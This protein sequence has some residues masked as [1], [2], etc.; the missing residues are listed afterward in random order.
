MAKTKLRYIN[1]TALNHQETYE[2]LVLSVV[3][4]ILSYGQKNLLLHIIDDVTCGNTPVEKKKNL[5]QASF[6][7]LY[8]SQHTDMKSVI[9]FYTR[10]AGNNFLASHFS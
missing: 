7:I 5:V 8:N 1:L 3:I 2:N 10:S 9:T 4:K 6:Y